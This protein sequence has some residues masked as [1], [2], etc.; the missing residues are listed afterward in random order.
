MSS[1]RPACAYLHANTGLCT[2]FD[3]GS[4]AE[5]VSQNINY[6]EPSFLL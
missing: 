5:E 1:T 6:D 3:S 4:F 2:S